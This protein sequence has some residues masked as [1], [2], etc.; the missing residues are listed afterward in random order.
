MF[1][2]SL[3]PAELSSHRRELVDIRI[4]IIDVLAPLPRGLSSEMTY[5]QLQ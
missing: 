3:C 1:R 4:A 5:V 2:E